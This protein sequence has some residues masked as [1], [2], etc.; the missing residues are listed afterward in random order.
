MMN[1]VV[2]FKSTLSRLVHPCLRALRGHMSQFHPQ[3]AWG[4][5]WMSVWVCDAK[6]PVEIMLI[7]TKRL[8]F[9]ILNNVVY[10]MQ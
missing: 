2:R 9:L 7:H 1:T 6:P 10:P 8:I 5:W 4:E 3:L